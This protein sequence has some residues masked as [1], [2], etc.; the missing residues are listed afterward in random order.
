MVKVVI[1]KT[2]FPHP[3]HFWLNRDES[4]PA[5]YG[6]NRFSTE[7]L[8]NILEKL[9][10]EKLGERVLPG[11]GVYVSRELRNLEIVYTRVFGYEETE[12]MLL[13]DVR[14]ISRGNVPSS[15]FIRRMG[16]IYGPLI[17]LKESQEVIEALNELGETPPHEWL[18][19]IDQE[20]LRESWLDWIPPR[21]SAMLEREIGNDEFEDRVAEIF[22][23]L[24]FEVEKYGHKKQGPYPDGIAKWR[25][26][27]AIVYDCK[28]RRN[29]VPKEEDIR[30]LRDYK[31]RVAYR[32]NKE[33]R[34]LY[35]A[36]IAISFGERI[37]PGEYKLFSIK[38]LLKQLYLRL[39]EG[40][41]YNPYDAFIRSSII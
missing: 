38:G 39:K 15:E 14:R 17:E 11:I 12:E 27:F 36:F 31:N 21:F 33:V 23:A 30:A 40:E 37:F 19:L 10:E 1:H 25:D 5:S 22:T 3:H 8:L 16:M 32:L 2:S 4:K 41:K 24:G 9:R 6:K 28:N 34:E 26:D 20:G 29:Y 13:L 18:Q 7:A 35:S